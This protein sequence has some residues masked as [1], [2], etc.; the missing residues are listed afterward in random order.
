MRGERAD[1]SVIIVA[2]MILALCIVAAQASKRRSSEPS[3]TLEEFAR[4]EAA[5]RFAGP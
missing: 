3:M 5:L 2:L 1:A 4:A